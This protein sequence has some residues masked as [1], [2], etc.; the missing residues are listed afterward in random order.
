MTLPDRETTQ[1]WLGQTVIDHGGAETGICRA[2]LAD[3]ATGLPEWLYAEL[4]GETVVIPLLDATAA[5]DR[6][7]VT[8]SREQVVASPRVGEGSEL[9]AAQETALY[10]HYGISYSTAASETVLPVG[11]V[12][13][14]PAVAPP[15]APAVASAEAPAVAS[16][17]A[18]AD[19]PPVAPA[20]ASD[21]DDVEASPAAAEADTVPPP[22]SPDAGGSAAR[23]GQLAGVLA[24]LGVLGAVVTAVLRRR[25][26]RRVPEPVG[27]RARLAA[28]ASAARARRRAR[29]VSASGAAVRQRLDEAASTLGPRARA[30]S[31]EA[32]ERAAEF[33]AAAAPVVAAA[34][35]GAQRAAGAGAATATNVANTTARIAAGTL[36]SGAA[37]GADL[38]QAGLRAALGV[39]GAAEAVPEVVAE[40]TDHLQK[41]W[42]RLMSKLSLGLGLGVGYV[43][44]ARAGRA[45]FEQIKQATAGFLERPEVQDAVGRVRAA[46]PPK[47]QSTLDGLSGRTSGSA[48]DVDRVIAVDSDGLATPESPAATTTPDLPGQGI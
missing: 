27:R 42:R 36:S 15:I 48:G 39:L 13:P 10:E 44:G 34:G 29:S 30:A 26:A 37:I 19:A 21:D 8:V 32:R 2:L 14:D 16:A 41:R 20:P 12:T 4:D 7:R 6:I 22:T 47:L 5:G 17:E 25:A 43:L 33:A 38:G 11:D 24:L 3:D 40:S 28:A 35:R 46:V 1:N 18:P 23:A 45:R 31:E 9:S